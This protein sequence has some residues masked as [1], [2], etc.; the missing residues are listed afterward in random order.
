MCAVLRSMA[1]EPDPLLLRLV[2]L[3]TLPNADLE[4]SLRGGGRRDGSEAGVPLADEAVEAAVRR[5]V[6]RMR[7]VG[8]TLVA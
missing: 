3:A 2:D 4:A 1:I 5:L 8:V 7:R 6:S